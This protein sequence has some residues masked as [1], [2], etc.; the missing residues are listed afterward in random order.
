M[1]LDS[2]DNNATG[3]SDEVGRHQVVVIYEETLD[4][5]GSTAHSHR[6]KTW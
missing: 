3:A 4:Y 1:H 6:D 5:K 2:E